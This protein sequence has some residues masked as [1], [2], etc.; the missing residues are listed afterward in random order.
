MLSDAMSDGGTASGPAGLSLDDL[1]VG[2]QVLVTVPHSKQ[3]LDVLPQRA[4]QNL[5]VVSTGSGPAKI[6]RSVERRGEDPRRVGVVPVL[7]SSVS[8]D[9]PLWV[10]DRTS[11]SD[12]TGLSIRFSEAAKHLKADTGWV[13]LDSLSTLYMYSDASS[14]Y[15]LVQSLT[16]TLR[17][18]EV[19]GVF[20]IA[21]GT[22]DGQTREQLR[23]L[24]DDTRT[25]METG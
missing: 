16:A 19:T 25:L 2:E 17:D 7:G 6:E 10:A 24:F 13:C 12:F 23:G 14:V 3:T 1:D 20:R 15:R 5:L 21:P 4:F 9:G 22:V 8:Y 11:P 18:H